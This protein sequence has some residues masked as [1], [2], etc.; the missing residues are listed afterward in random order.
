MQHASGERGRF[1][2]FDYHA[3]ALQRGDLLIKPQKISRMEN[4]LDVLRRFRE[5]W[6]FYQQ[7]LVPFDV[8]EATRMCPD[9]LVEIT[10]YLS[11]TDAINAFSMSILPVL[12]QAHSKVHLHN[13]PDRFVQ[14]IVQY[15]DPRQITSVHIND[16]VWRPTWDL[17]AFHMFDQ[18]VSVTVFSQRGNNAIGSFLHYFPTARYV[19]LWFA[20]EFDTVLFL[21]LRNVSPL[22]MT[23]LRIRCTGMR[24]FPFRTGKQQGGSSKNTTITSFIFDSTY[25]TTNPSER[26]AHGLPQVSPLVKL[27][28]PMKF[29]ASLRNV[30]H[31]RL[32]VDDDQAETFLEVD[33]WQ[34]LISECVHLQ[35]VTIKLLDEGHFT[36]QAVSIEQMLCRIRPG[37]RFRIKSA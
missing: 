32:I 30:R 14:M 22:R 34:Q 8:T 37:I 31:V 17:S 28:I 7:F 12:R 15:L 21:A 4:V 5:E 19:S 11:L 33:Q 1:S 25:K 26:P 18:L 35:R 9:V 27:P 2:P 24:F 6:H 16:N 23:H 36:Q 29:I 3:R 20:F 13:P 10:K